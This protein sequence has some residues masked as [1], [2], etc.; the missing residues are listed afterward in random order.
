M[1]SIRNS[2]NEEEKNS[3]G[4]LGTPREIRAAYDIKEHM[5]SCDGWSL[6]KKTKFNQQPVRRYNAL[7]AE[8]FT[9]NR[10]TVCAHLTNL[11]NTFV[12]SQCYS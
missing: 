12:I 8:N 6:F 2:A 7:V 9:R 10:I 3:D 11:Y 5:Q 1:Q 4:E